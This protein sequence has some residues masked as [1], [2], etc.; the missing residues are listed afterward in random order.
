MTHEEMSLNTKKALAESLKKAMGQKPFHKI[1]VSELIEACGINRKTFYYH[2]ENIYTLLKWTLEQESVEVVKH[3]NLLVDHEEAI[4]FVMDYV[5]RNDHILNCAYDA[6]GRDELK[7]FFY[8]D[9]M[10][11]SRSLLDAKE[12]A[13]GIT[14][15]P[16]YKDFLAGFY[17][18]AV[19]GVLV[20]WIRDRAHRDRAATVRFLISAIRDTLSGVFTQSGH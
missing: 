14:L 9:F 19:S 16:G 1:S 15:E 11:I 3:F 8:A 13:A 12:Q 4:V 10:E 2:F 6:I 18:N 20:D 17:A 7:R 5:E